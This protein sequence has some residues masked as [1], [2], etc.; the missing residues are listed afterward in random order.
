VERD[1]DGLLARGPAVEV[2][3]VHGLDHL[4]VEARLFA[5][6]PAR[7]HHRRLARLDPP[8]PRLPL[9]RRVVLV[10]AAAHEQ[11]MPVSL[12]QQHDDAQ[13]LHGK[14]GRGKRNTGVRS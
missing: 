5:R 9:A 14:M 6:L 4:H 11:Q 13:E 3:G 12:D 1:G 2:E 7:R 10:G 8:A